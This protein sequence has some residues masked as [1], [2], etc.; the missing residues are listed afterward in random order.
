MIAVIDYGAS[1]IRSVLNALEELGETVEIVSRPEDLAGA[2]RIILPGVGA[3]APAVERLREAEMIEALTEAVEERR[4]PFLGICLGMQMMCSRGREGRKNTSCFDW[5]E[6]E[7]E[8][9]PEAPPERL[10]PHIG[11]AEVTA[12]EDNPLFEGLRPGTAFYF[13][14]SFHA[15]PKD[16]TRLAATAAFGEPIAAALWRGA[17]MGVQFHPERSGQAGLRLL[18]NFLDWDGAGR[19]W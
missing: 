9:L 16:A 8:E 6:G 1:N 4:T 18:E 13:C 17:A 5:I 15:V 10:V 7:V 12:A 11:W 14:H 2:E 3:I 19:A